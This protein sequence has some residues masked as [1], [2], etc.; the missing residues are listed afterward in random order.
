MKPWERGWESGWCSTDFNVLA[1][2]AFELSL[3][4]VVDGDG[5]LRCEP[6]HEVQVV[7]WTALSGMMLLMEKLRWKGL[8]VRM[9]S[10]VRTI[11]IIKK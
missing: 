4:E 6:V 7:L 9:A 8:G 2:M 5:Q 11:S 10:V 1:V 3:G